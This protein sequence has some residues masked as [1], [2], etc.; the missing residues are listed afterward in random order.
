MCQKIMLKVIVYKKYL[1]AN[2]KRDWWIYKFVLASANLRITYLRAAIKHF[3]RSYIFI[4]KN[5]GNIFI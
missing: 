2:R 3:R 5:E 4:E 1:G